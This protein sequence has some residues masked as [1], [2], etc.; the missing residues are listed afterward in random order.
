MQICS[1]IPRLK[2]TN[3][4]PAFFSIIGILCLL[5]LQLYPLL[6][7]TSGPFSHYMQFSPRRYWLDCL[8]PFSISFNEP[9]IWPMAFCVVLYHSIMHHGITSFP[10]QFLQLDCGL[11]WTSPHLSLLPSPVFSKIPKP[12]NNWMWTHWNTLLWSTEWNLVK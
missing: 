3:G 6:L 7:A 12:L 10:A 11:L 4:H 9:Y 2:I 1:N 5:T 8:P